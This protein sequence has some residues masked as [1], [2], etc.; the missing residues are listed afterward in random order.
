VRRGILASWPGVVVA[1]CTSVA[2]LA[3]GVVWWL[4]APTSRLKVDSGAAYYVDP[5]PHEFVTADLRFALV[6]TLG[7]VVVGLG[8][9]WVP[10]LRARPTASVVGLAVG[11]VLGSL[12]GWWIGTFLG[13]VDVVALQR[14]PD[15][16]EFDAP[17]RLT[18]IGVLAFLP[19]ADLVGSALASRRERSAP[20]D[21]GHPGPAGDTVVPDWGGVAVITDA[22]P[23]PPWHPS[24]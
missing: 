20:A 18:A 3:L 5:Q 6:M 21:P 14:S 24:P 23:A 8:V 17:L 4:I 19:V 10:T 22:P 7:G 12:G 2:G 9:W 11:G 15:G 16:T 1:W 13:R